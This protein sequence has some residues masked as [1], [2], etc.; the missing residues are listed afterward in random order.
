MGEPAISEQE[1]LNRV[2]KGPNKTGDNADG[3]V[4]LPYQ[5]GSDNQWHRSPGSLV[6][7]AYDY[8]AFSDPDG[9]GNYQTIQFYQGGSGGTVVAT[10]SLT[11]D[12]SN[13]V[14]SIARS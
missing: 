2:Y 4:I 11:F 9:N 1:I 10:L 5:F 14:T 13:N 8:N 7:V 3:L 12:G 6:N